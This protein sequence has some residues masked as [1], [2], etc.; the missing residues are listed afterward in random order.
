MK[1]MPHCGDNENYHYAIIII[2]IDDIYN[3]SKKKNKI[4]ID[5]DFI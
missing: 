3:I 2:I 1:Q 5:V 4:N